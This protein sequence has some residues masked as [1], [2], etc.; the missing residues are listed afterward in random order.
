MSG[1]FQGKTKSHL[2]SKFFILG[3]KPSKTRSKI[4]GKGASRTNS[5]IQIGKAGLAEY[6]YNICAIISSNDRL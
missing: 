1:T 6:F 5:R 4:C 2:S 3:T